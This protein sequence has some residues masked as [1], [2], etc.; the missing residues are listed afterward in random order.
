MLVFR[1]FNVCKIIGFGK[2]W[3]SRKQ[4]SKTIMVCRTTHGCL[5]KSAQKIVMRSASLCWGVGTKLT[6]YVLSVLKRT[7][8][9]AKPGRFGGSATARQNPDLC[10]TEFTY[11]NSNQ[12]KPKWCSNFEPNQTGTEYP[13]DT[14]W[15]TQWDDQW[16]AQWDIPLDSVLYLWDHIVLFL[17][18]HFKFTRWMFS[19]KASMSCI[20]EPMCYKKKWP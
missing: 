2:H 10:E 18:Y 12:F 14:P 5:E 6:S 3:R 7:R 20:F 15:Y 9:G 1:S 11:I 4:I 8:G 16:D 19:T 17:W 13:W